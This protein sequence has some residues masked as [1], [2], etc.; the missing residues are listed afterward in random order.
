[1]TTIF[2]APCEFCPEEDALQVQA[3][4][5]SLMFV[6]DDNDANMHTSVVLSPDAV[7]KLRDELTKWL[8]SIK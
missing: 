5:R 2:E 6:G 1:M 7:E 8:E 4:K 3:L